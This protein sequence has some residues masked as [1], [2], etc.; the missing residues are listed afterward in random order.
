MIPMDWISGGSV[1]MLAP[2]FGSWLTVGYL[3]VAVTA[4]SRVVLRDH[5]VAQVVAGAV[6]GALAALVTYAI[7][8]H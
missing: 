6:L 7:I 2:L 4:W 3:L 5:T 1:T 8:P